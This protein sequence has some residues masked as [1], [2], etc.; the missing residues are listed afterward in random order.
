MSKPTTTKQMLIDAKACRKQVD[1]FEK[2]FGDS[3]VVT[4][5][6]AEKVAHLFQWDW[7]TRLLD[8]QGR[9][10][11]RC[12]IEEAQ[13]K[14][15]RVIAPALAELDHTKSGAWDEYRRVTAPAQAELDHTKSGAWDEYRRVKK[16]AEAEYDRVE[17]AAEAEY[18]RTIATA[19]ASAFIDMHKRG[20]TALA[21]AGSEV[22]DA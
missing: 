7:G 6:R 14:L 16:A 22:Y 13:A 2:T 21:V 19:W 12:G 5:K 4:I 1:L 3:V 9:A 18:D 11:Y 15:D 17:A 20:I 10:E 8:A